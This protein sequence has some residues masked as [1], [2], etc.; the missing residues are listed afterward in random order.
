MSSFIN[1]DFM[2][3]GRYAKELYHGRA[4]HMPIIEY[5]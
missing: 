2:L 4:A 1:E 5:S 3:S